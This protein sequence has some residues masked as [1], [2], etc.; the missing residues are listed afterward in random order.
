ASV[1]PGCLAGFVGE[2]WIIARDD[3]PQDLGPQGRTVGIRPNEAVPVM[4]E[5]QVAAS[6][7]LAEHGRLPA[8][9]AD[10]DRNLGLAR[11]VVKCYDTSHECERIHSSAGPASSSSFCKAGGSP[12]KEETRCLRPRCGGNPRD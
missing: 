8:A 4:I 9:G 12:C 5:G 11:L 1:V 7:H 6:A 2:D 10:H 3:P